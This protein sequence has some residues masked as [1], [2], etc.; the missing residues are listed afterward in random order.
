[1][2]SEDNVELFTYIAQ[3]LKPQGLAYLHVMDGTGLNFPFY[4][5]R[6]ISLKK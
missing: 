3:Q 5:E 1:M 6:Y 2:G 4:T